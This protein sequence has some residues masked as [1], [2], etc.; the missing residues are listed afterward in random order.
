M[1]QVTDTLLFIEHGGIKLVYMKSNL[2][3]LKG[4]LLTLD[5]YCLCMSNFYNFNKMVLIDYFKTLIV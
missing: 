2:K 1:K 3:M 5:F 4:P